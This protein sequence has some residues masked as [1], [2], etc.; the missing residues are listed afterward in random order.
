MPSCV[1]FLALSADLHLPIIIMHCWAG[2]ELSKVYIIRLPLDLAMSLLTWDGFCLNLS[3]SI[4]SFSF[5]D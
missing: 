1:S 3:L 2:P 5:L 4:L